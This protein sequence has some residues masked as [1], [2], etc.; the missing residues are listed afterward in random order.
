MQIYPEKYDQLELTVEEKSFLRTVQRAFSEEEMSYYVL[1]IN[2]RKKSSHGSPEL[3]N[4]MVIP[5]GILL[6]RFLNA[7]AA[8]IAVLF[9][10]SL[11]TP[12]VYG[13][14]VN[15]IQS[16]LEESRYLTDGQGDLNHAM[17]ICFVL[18][19][20]SYAELADSL[21]RDQQIF[22][23]QHV[24]FKDNI[25]SIRKSGA[26]ILLNKLP[27]S[28]QVTEDLVN[29][30]FQRLCPELTIPRKFILDERAPVLA[31]DGQ[32]S[33]NDRAVQ[34]YRLDDRQI[35]IIN[36]ISK[37]NQLILACAGSGKSVLLISKCFKLASLNPD[38][39]FLITCYN[40][41]LY[42]YYQWA[43]AQAGFTD[44]NVRCAT[45]FGLCK[46]LLESNHLT[47]PAHYN[48]KQNSLDDYY[49]RM[50][51]TAN[52]ALASERIKERFYG[53]FIDEVQIFKPEWYR[54]CFN[55]LC[56]KNADDHF[57]VIAGD[58]SQD[59]KNNIKNSRAPWQGGGS[60]YPEYRGKT[61]PI[62]TNYRNSKQINDAIDRFVTSAK[63]CGDSLGADLTS[64]PELFLR[65]TAYREGSKPQVIELRDLS[66]EGEAA[67]ICGEIKRL[68][69]VKG[70]SE[71][72]IAV[73]LYNRH[74]KYTTPG[75]ATSYYNLLAPI[76]QRFYQEGWENPAILISGE[77]EGATYG[78]RRGVTIA[79]IEG[80]L[81]LDFRAVIL[82]GL[83]PLGIHE[84]ARTIDEIQN[85]SGE[86]H[87]QKLEAFKK[88]INFIYT[89][90]TRAKDELTIILSAPKGQSIYMDLIR[91][92]MG[93]NG[94]HD[95]G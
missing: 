23:Q 19:N 63:K 32:V 82:A 20:F 18:P 73:I 9:I 15:D 84:K 75:W 27:Y 40:R 67:A 38:Q 71:V 29:N 59:I 34:S 13:S 44:K 31:H 79:T 80:S 1:H 87:I 5:K 48:A 90:C 55:L 42:H 3:F 70:L 51:E 33:N 35:N 8:E 64:D 39:H 95:N 93:G 45:F 94:G 68:I 86:S 10:Q 78:S 62:E 11:S 30:I 92:S 52:G 57:F 21:S 60:Q 49:D 14:L 47:L 25:L 36:K 74:A 24:I 83:R 26:E 54:F 53:I 41:N 69:E 61:L 89:G 50:F 17:N 81:G 6:F 77:S 43:I 16:R 85:S 28:T 22:C 91:E 72:D 46:Q 88:N 65:G 56:S 37:G 7:A 66:N 12:V 2:P 76:K 4:L 58:K